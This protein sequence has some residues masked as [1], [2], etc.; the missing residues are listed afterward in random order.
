MNYLMQ[1][2]PNVVNPQMVVIALSI[3]RITTKTM[4][5]RAKTDALTFHLKRDLKALYMNSQLQAELFQLIVPAR[6]VSARCNPLF[7]GSEEEA[8]S[9][10]CIQ[11]DLFEMLDI[12]G[13]GLFTIYR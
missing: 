12:T 8:M 1:S 9:Q 10:T 11:F 13:G 7:H 2:N 5:F 6:P 3:V 4:P